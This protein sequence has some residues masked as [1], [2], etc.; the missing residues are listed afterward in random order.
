MVKCPKMFLAVIIG[1][2]L[3]GTVKHPT[4][5]KT[6]PTQRIN[7]AHVSAVPRVSTE[8]ARWQPYNRYSSPPFSVT[9][10]P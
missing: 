4:E 7:S 2:A 8:S 9:G 10:A 5:H 1:R 3:S 6:A